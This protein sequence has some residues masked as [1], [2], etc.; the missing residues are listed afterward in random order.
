MNIL[1]RFNVCVC[2]SYLW[3]LKFFCCWWV[4]LVCLCCWW[5]L[6]VCLCCWWVPLVCL[7]CWW[8]PLVCLCCWV[9]LVCL[10]CWWVPLVCLCCWWVPL[11]CHI[12]MSVISIMHFNCFQKNLYNEYSV[13]HDV[14][15]LT[16]DKH[17]NFHRSN[18]WLESFESCCHVFNVNYTAMN[19]LKNHFWIMFYKLD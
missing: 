2:R 4:P 11:V 8:V 19:F 17:C 9:P 5:V 14:Q 1:T 10:C 16:L 15:H 6:L 3:V 13:I 18:G 7:C 12:R